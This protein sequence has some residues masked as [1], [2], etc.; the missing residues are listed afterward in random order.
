MFVTVVLLILIA[1][2]IAAAF[3][4]ECSLCRQEK[5]ERGAD[6]PTEHVV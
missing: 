5:A 1:G 3:Y 4:T 6:V 2:L